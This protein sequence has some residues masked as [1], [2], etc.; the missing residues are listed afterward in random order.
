MLSRSSLRRAI[1]STTKR[2]NFSISRMSNGLK[3]IS[4]NDGTGISGLGVFS[5]NAT[6]F[7][8][9]HTAGSAA[10]LESL[11]LRGNEVHGVEDIGKILGSLGN[12]YKVS[13]N[14]EAMGTMVFA[15]RYHV[16]EGLQ[17]LNGM[18][19]RPTKNVELFNE[20]KE[21]VRERTRTADR[22]ATKVCFELIHKA[23]WGG[24]GLGNESLPTEAQLDALTLENF[25]LFHSTFTRPERTVV[26]GTGVADH[27]TFALM[28]EEEMTFPDAPSN[29]NHIAIC[30][31]QPYCG[32]TQLLHNTKAPDSTKKF[33]ERNLT[34]MGIMYQGVPINHPDYYPVSLI[35]SLLGG[36][37]SF[38]SGGPG[39]GMQTKLFREVLHREG[40]IH[41]IEC[42]SAWYSDGG[43]IGLYASAPHEWA[44]HLRHVCLYQFASIPDRID[45]SQ[46]EM[47]KN[48]LCSQLVLLG[49]GREQLLSDTGFNLVLHDYAILEDEVLKGTESVTM[50]DIRR[51]CDGM[52]QKPITFAVYGET[53]GIPEHAVLEQQVRALHTKFS[54]GYR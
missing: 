15:P 52:V 13:N 16:R 7:E 2:G 22:D 9:E 14:K 1:A 30:V 11:P 3:V 24:K 42:I 8:N 10:I 40:W 6:K 34:H 36:G 41:G 28:C 46:L 44:K 12:A 29:A 35:Q 39:K 33:Q 48:Q 54:A 27:A 21:L 43:M 20:V 25:H 38:S 32:G 51:V 17:L 4:S 18:C 23:A 26:A 47:A 45:A 31:D 50:A 37:T 49:E 5:L 53:A 19:L